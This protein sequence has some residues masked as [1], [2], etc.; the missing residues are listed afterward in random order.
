M[1]ILGLRWGLEICPF[2][3][4]PDICD[5][6]NSL[7]TCLEILFQY[8]GAANLPY[9]LTIKDLCHWKP[10][11]VDMSVNLGIWFCKI[12]TGRSNLWPYLHASKITSHWAVFLNGISNW[13]LGRENEWQILYVSTCKDKVT[14]LNLSTGRMEQ[15][16]LQ[17]TEY[18]AFF[19][20]LNIFPR[21]LEP[22]SHI[23]PFPLPIPLGCNRT[24][25]G[26]LSASGIFPFHC[27]WE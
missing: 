21:P 8:I 10:Y 15:N 17:V 14:I 20:F 5:K 13:L 12:C 9:S 27:R 19:F 7:A 2:R 23:H 16:F 26:C 1:K 24:L 18:T 4:F 3:S 25:L 6:R 22:P 11:S